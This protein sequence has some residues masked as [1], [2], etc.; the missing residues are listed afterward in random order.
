MSRAG[1]DDHSGQF[2]VGV[3]PPAPLRLA[4]G[5]ALREALGPECGTPIT[6]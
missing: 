6:G 3:R 1:P 2:A 5:A 4:A